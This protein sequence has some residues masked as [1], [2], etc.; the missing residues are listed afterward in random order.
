MYLKSDT[1]LL[2]DVFN[3]FKV[4]LVVSTNIDILLIIEKGIRGGICHA[5]YRYAKASNKYIKDYH[6]NKESPY[7]NFCDVNLLYG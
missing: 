5:I 6:K 2:A 1:L 4:K 7:H 3:N